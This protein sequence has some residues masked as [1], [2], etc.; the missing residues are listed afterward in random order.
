MIVGTYLITGIDESRDEKLGAQKGKRIVSARLYYPADYN[1]ESEVV[2]RNAAGKMY[3]NP[4]ILNRKNSLVI[5]NHGYG[6]YMEANNKLCCELV[7]NG[8]FVVSVGH[9]YESAYM[10]LADGSRI[11]L[12]KNVKGKQVDPMVRG[13]IAALKMKK[14]NGTAKEMYDVF[15]IFQKKYCT[16]LNERLKEWAE[17]VNFIVGILKKE[18]CDYIDFEKG[19][20]VMGHSF[21]G[22]LAY[23]MCM[24][25]EEYICGANMDGAIFG[26]YY[27][28]TMERPFLQILSRN[29][30]AVVSKVLLDTN[31]P[32]EYE[33]FDGITH[34]GF[35]DMK[36]FSKSKMMMG[37]MSEDDVGNKMKE[38]HL[39]FFNHYLRK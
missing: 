21:G 31:A 33:M 27:G 12:D 25:Y 26:E 15:Y 5:Y 34:M 10:E 36:Y 30:E 28:Q 29:N 18:Y 38:L 16:F 6:S 39:N 14:T 19:I 32:V 4:D 13:T 23:Y 8:Y 11:E 37:K 1:G 2:I 9:A 7:E 20:G 24:N 3:Q 17:D 35:T 22:N